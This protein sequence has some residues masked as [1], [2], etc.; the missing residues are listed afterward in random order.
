M[1]KKVV[2]L[3][4]NLNVGGLETYLLRFLQC[5]HFK[6]DEI[7]VVCK[8]GLGGELENEYSS[9]FNVSIK[10]LRLSYF[11]VFGYFKFF[12]FLKSFNPISVCDFTGDFAGLTLYA[13]KKANVPNRLVFYRDSKYQF[14]ITRFK[15]LYIFFLKKLLG[16]SATRYLSNSVEAFNYFHPQWAEAER[17]RYRVIYNGVPAFPPGF[18]RSAFRSKLGFKKSDFIIGHVGSYRSA[19]NHSVIVDVAAF[20]VKKIPEVKFLL[21]GKDVE[22]GLSERLTKEGLTNHFFLP[23]NQKDV[24][25]YLS[26]MDVFLFP[27]LNE[28]QPNALIEAQL[29]GI[30]IVASDIPTIK[31]STPSVVSPYLHPPLDADLFSQS[32]LSIYADGCIYDVEDVSSWAKTEF[33][34]SS[35]FSEFLQE[36]V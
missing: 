10:F 13:S 29:A 31:E 11:N 12:F 22:S 20:L 1:K 23:G 32:I 7:A 19:K 16:L 9:Y 14:R 27:S 26:V 28:G 25:N 21:V 3:V 8:Q 36:L 24:V 33:D 15:R 4:S 5:S 17:S 2:F 35:R 6:F 34:P 18:R 30:P